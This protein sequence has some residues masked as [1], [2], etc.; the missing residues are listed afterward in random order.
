[1]ASR[2]QSEQLTRR[3]I[4]SV[5]DG[6]AAK[7][8]ASEAAE[9]ERRRAQ[10]LQS[11]LQAGGRPRPGLLSEAQSLAESYLRLVGRLA[12]GESLP[13]AMTVRVRRAD[14]REFE[15]HAARWETVGRLKELIRQWQGNFGGLTVR[16]GALNDDARLLYDMWLRDELGSRTSPNPPPVQLIVTGNYGG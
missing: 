3:A 10:D 5:A 11:E 16:G 4:A 2:Q 12:P 7:G 6:S 1:M 9:N 13:D 15:V 14:G 8:P